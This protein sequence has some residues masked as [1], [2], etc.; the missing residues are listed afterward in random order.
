MG[1]PLRGAAKMPADQA[2][3][4]PP[5]NIIFGVQRKM[6]LEYDTDI[7]ERVF[8]IVLTMRVAVGIEE[9]E[10]I[11]KATNIGDE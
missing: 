10:M 1:I 8:I 2:L 9:E 6:R 4:T 3:L 5:G 11:V 7:R